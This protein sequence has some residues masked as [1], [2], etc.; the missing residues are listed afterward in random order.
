MA[1][2]YCFNGSW[3]LFSHLRGLQLG[4]PPG[5]VI[6]PLLFNIL[7]HKVACSSFPWHT[8]VI[9]YAEDIYL[10]CDIL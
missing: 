2:S 4:A 1:I 9:E 6:S 8:N 3:L 7:M 10:Q 5:G